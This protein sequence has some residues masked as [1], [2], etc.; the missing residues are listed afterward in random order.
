[1]RDKR[2]IVVVTL[3]LGLLG[4]SW[5]LGMQ[6]NQ[7]SMT[8]AVAFTEYYRIMLNNLRSGTRALK[9]YLANPSEVLLWQGNSE[10]AAAANVARPLVSLVPKGMNGPWSRF[11]RKDWDMITKSLDKVN[12]RAR[13]YHPDR[14]PAADIKYLKALIVELESIIDAM[15]APIVSNGS[16]PGVRLRMDEV[17]SMGKKVDVAVAMAESYLLNGLLPAEARHAFVSETAAEILARNAFELDLDEWQL[18]EVR[19]AIIEI[20]Q[21]R[22]FHILYFTPTRQYQGDKTGLLVGVH[23]QTG[24]IVLTEWEKP[25]A[26]TA[27][28][29][30]A[31]QLEAWALAATESLEGE[32]MVYEIYQPEKKHPWAVVVRLQNDIPVLTDY[33]IVGFDQA[34]GELLKWENHN[35][36]TKLSNWQPRMQSEDVVARLAL[37]INVSDLSGFEHKGLVVARSQITDQPTLCYWLT[38]TDPELMGQVEPKVGHYFVNANNGRLE[39]SGSGW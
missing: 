36:G 10:I 33:V 4:I 15:D 29:V 22:D 27:E 17:E 30:T 8:R 2:L 1:M 19:P 5:Y 23:R 32:K 11:M 12:E 34:T 31:S 13:Y 28:P 25:V 35:W 14:L 9:D 37:K 16:A 24:E 7:A 26:K 18:K 21:G 20:R 6:L 39:R 38:Y 3:V